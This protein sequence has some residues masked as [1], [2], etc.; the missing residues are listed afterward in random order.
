[1]QTNQ[2]RHFWS[3]RLQLAPCWVR[4]KENYKQLIFSVVLVE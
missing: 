2:A 3:I 1:M 4:V